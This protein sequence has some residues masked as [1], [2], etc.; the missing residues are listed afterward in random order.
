MA[1]DLGAR[2]A[3]RLARQHD[4]DAERLQAL[5]EQ[6]GMGGFAAAVA[7]LECDEAP[8]QSDPNFSVSLP[9]QAGNPVIAV[10]NWH[11]CIIQTDAR[12]IPDGP[13]SRGVTG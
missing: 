1:D 12:R 11:P 7:A 6:L 10:P 2:R 13:L 5:G 9:A 8:P 3:A 4:L